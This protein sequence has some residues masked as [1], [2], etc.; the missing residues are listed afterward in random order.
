VW[1]DTLD[2][3]PVEDG[4]ISEQSVYN[5]GAR[6]EASRASDSAMNGESVRQVKCYLKKATGASGTITCKVSATSDNTTRAVIGTY[7]AGD[8]STSYELITFG[9]VSTTSYTLVDGDTI[10]VEF[11]DTGTIYTRQTNNYSAYDG[12]KSGKSY[13]LYTGV[14]A[15]WNS[16]GGEDWIAEFSG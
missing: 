3:S 9:G 11:G 7:E 8:L 1:Y 6:G 16:D 4:Q 13:F 14:E 5:I 15:G 2:G 10:C 12:T